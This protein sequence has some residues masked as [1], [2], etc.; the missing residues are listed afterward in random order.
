MRVG[1]ATRAR[2]G[3]PPWPVVVLAIGVLVWVTADVLRGGPLT[4]LDRYVAD[5]AWAAQIRH[6]NLPRGLLVYAGIMPGDPLGV[7]FVVAPFVA[8]LAYWRRSWQP[9]LRFVVALGLLWLVVD[10]AKY[11]IGRTSPGLVDRLHVGGRSYPSGHAATAV[12]MT[13]LVSS[14]AVQAGLPA[15]WQ[16]ILRVLAVLAPLITAT[17]MVLLVYHWLTDVLA[18]LAVGVLLLGVHHLI[19]ASR[20]G[21][22]PAASRL[23][24]YGAGGGPSNGP[25]DGSGPEDAA[26]RARVG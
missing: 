4:R 21:D 11:G 13:G 24:R 18:G 15:A 25:S 14:L 9:V 17:S 5:W 26:A 8:G 7:G 20:L 1:P 19:F 23:D 6:G 2:G 10:V 22:W 3:G 16:R 12:V